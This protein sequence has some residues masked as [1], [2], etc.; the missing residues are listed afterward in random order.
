METGMGMGCISCLASHCLIVTGLGMG[1][2]VTGCRK[3][4]SI[5]SWPGMPP[6]FH[7]PWCLPL[8]PWVS[9]FGAVSAK[10]PQVMHQ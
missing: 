6:A 2:K 4:F 5:L 3:D 7:G 8:Q 1:S 9:S 10:E